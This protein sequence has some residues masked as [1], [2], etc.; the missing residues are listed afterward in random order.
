M[1]DLRTTS[2]V[3]HNG[4][5]SMIEL[6]VVMGIVSILAIAAGQLI[7]S[8]FQRTET[9]HYQTHLMTVVEELWT[10]RQRHGVFPDTVRS[11]IDARVTMASCGEDCIAVRLEPLKPHRCGYWALRTDGERN[12]GSSGCW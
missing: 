3:A 1:A 9:L 7:G 8:S 12:A 6:L 10:H 2:G 4:G 11:R 5:F